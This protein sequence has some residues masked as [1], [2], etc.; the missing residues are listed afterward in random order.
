MSIR[1]L[2]YVVLNLSA[3]VV[4]GALGAA[5]GYGTITM[6]DVPDFVGAVIAATIAMVVATAAWAAGYVMLR[7]VGFVR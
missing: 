1:T 4:C 3:I 2:T 5:A 7:A 6:L